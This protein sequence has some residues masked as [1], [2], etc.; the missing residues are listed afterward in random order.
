MHNDELCLKQGLLQIENQPSARR[1]CRSQTKNKPPDLLKLGE[2][3]LSS[4]SLA[5]MLPLPT[6]QKLYADNI[7]GK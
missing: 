3:A 6:L 2:N 5:S 7:V 1:N 4:R